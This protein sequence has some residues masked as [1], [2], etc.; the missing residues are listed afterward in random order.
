VL[1]PRPV[2]DASCMH[3]SLVIA[4]SLR[5]ACTLLILG[6]MTTASDR[7]C[8]FRL[9]AG[10]EPAGHDEARIDKLVYMPVAWCPSARSP[11]IVRTQSL[12][13]ASAQL[14]SA[15]TTD[16]WKGGLLKTQDDMNQRNVFFFSYLASQMILLLE[17]LTM[18]HF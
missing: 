2:P 9:T 14:S 18:S 7:S 17:P 4:D 11:G 8:A 16:R 3:G 13:S 5:F 15:G 10:R 6:F 12:G 1:N